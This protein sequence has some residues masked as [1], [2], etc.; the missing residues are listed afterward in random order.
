MGY[1]VIMMKVDFGNFYPLV[2]MQW[3]FVTKAECR[4]VDW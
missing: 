2:P 3:T 4:N 1:S